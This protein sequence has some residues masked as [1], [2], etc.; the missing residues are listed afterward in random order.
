MPLWITV[1]SPGSMSKRNAT[2]ARIAAEHVTRLSA[3]LASH[4][5]TEWTC[6]FRGWESQPLWRA[7]LGG[8]VGGPGGG[9]AAVAAGFGGG[10]G[11]HERAAE[12]LGER[13]GGVGD[14]PVVGVD[15]V[16][17]PVEGE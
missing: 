15:H 10:D 7:G 3:R 17:A 8:G 1:M 14:E 9:A 13:H 11:R 12:V 16:R 2:S 6:W 5:S 4:H